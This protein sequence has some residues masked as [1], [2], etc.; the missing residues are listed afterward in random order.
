VIRQIVLLFIV[1]QFQGSAGGFIA[2][3]SGTNQRRLNNAIGTP[4]L[5]L[6]TTLARLGLAA[7]SPQTKFRVFSDASN[8]LKTS[9]MASNSNR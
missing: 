5:S 8:P 6:T 9:G 1:L 2:C 7:R 4:T 3:G